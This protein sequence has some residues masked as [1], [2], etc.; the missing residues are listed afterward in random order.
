MEA[1]EE[2][3][4]RVLSRDL[5]AIALQ[6]LPK[7]ESE[8]LVLAESG[9][10]LAVLDSLLKDVVQQRDECEKKKLK[11]EIKGR[12]VILR[13]LADKAITWID[14]FKEIGDV[15]VNF[16]P[17]HAALPWAGIRFLLQVRLRS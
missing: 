13:D 3:C 8:N 5:W 10:K 6:S 14:K 17:V 7:E 2:D 4:H 16:D 9:S 1:A 15:A 11:F 12:Q